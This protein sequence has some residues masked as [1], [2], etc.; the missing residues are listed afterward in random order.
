M[1]EKGAERAQ[2]RKLSFYKRRKNALID[3]RILSENL[4]KT[5]CK[6]QRISRH[7]S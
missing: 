3:T 6:H 2:A 7:N 5:D 4:S 1:K